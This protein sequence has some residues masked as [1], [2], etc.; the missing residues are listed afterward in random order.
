[1]IIELILL[2]LIH[3]YFRWNAL[4]R[5]HGTVCPGMIGCYM[6]MYS[7]PVYK[8]SA[9]IFNGIVSC[10][11]LNPRPDYAFDELYAF[12][13]WFLEFLVLL[14]WLYCTNHYGW[15][16]LVMLCLISFDSEVTW[17]LDFVFDT[18]CGLFVNNMKLVK[19][20]VLHEGCL[21]R[22]TCL[23]CSTFNY[24]KYYLISRWP[25]LAGPLSFLGSYLMP[26]MQTTCV[27][28]ILCSIV[29]IKGNDD[30]KWIS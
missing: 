3:V 14:H 21:D 10:F 19:C 12:Y 9:T 20:Y 27:H 26:V 8:I 29:S 2:E 4:A 30:K 1:M 25:Y 5:S 24:K 15:K 6:H 28:F 22:F 18:N 17:D 13:F 7:I 23:V 11:Y 16:R